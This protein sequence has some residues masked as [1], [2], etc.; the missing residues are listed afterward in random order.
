MKRITTILKNKLE[1]IMNPK[2]IYNTFNSKNT[3]D[4]DDGNDGDKVNVISIDDVHTP[5]NRP[6][7]KKSSPCI[8][9]PRHRS[10]TVPLPVTKASPPHLNTS[11]PSLELY[12]NYKDDYVVG[13]DVSYVVDSIIDDIV[14]SHYN[15]SSSSFNSDLCDYYSDQLE[16]EESLESILSSREIESIRQNVNGILYKERDFLL[17]LRSIKIYN[18][19][20]SCNG[21][22]CGV[23]KTHDLVVKIDT[24]PE[25]FK[26]ELFAM[27]FLGKGIIK[28]HNLVLPYIV[29]IYQYNKGRHMNFS[30]QPRIIDSLTIYDWMKIR[31]NKNLPINY[32]ITT[33]INVCKSILF[34][35]SKHVVHGDIKPGNILIQNTTNIPFIIDFGL[36]GIHAISEGTGGTK[37]FCHPETLNISNDEE[38]S[39]EWTKTYKNNDLWS[40]V[41]LFST[42]IIFRTCYHLYTEYPSDFFDLEKYMNPTYLHHIPYHFR[43]AF[44]LV[45]VNPKYRVN[46]KKINVRKFIHLLEVGL[47]ATITPLGV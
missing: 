8:D 4:A 38:E 15:S 6:L 35:H 44:Q 7:L 24:S 32:Y 39:Y 14:T 42:I 43:D 41:L 3:D 31:A 22:R 2:T 1:Y 25:A 46:A 37:P 27:S 29:K 16:Y 5:E 18:N 40:I 33:C 21:V 30:I 17:N 20:L 23:F 13:L 10:E 19:D 47:H 34:V 26:C 45:I 28:S 12:T 11:P 36:S 9:T